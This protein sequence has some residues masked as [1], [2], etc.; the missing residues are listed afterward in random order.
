MN[1]DQKASA[2]PA[3]AAIWSGDSLGYARARGQ[4]KLVWL[5]EAVKADVEPHN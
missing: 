4:R 2:D 3:K 1:P 5:L